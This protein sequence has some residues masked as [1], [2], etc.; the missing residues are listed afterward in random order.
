[1]KL[2]H[3]TDHDAVA[4]IFESG[5]N[6]QKAMGLSSPIWLQELVSCYTGEREG[7]RISVHF[8]E[9]YGNE[10]LTL[11]LLCSSCCC[12]AFSAPALF[13][14]CFACSNLSCALDNVRKCDSKPQD[15]RSCDLESCDPSSHVTSSHVTPQVM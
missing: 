2:Q 3:S 14:S 5:E 4:S 10:R 9:K 12:A 11:S 7:G 8:T 13:S 6:W 1:M 15:I